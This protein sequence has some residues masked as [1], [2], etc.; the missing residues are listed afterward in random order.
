MYEVLICHQTPEKVTL[1]LDTT[2][3][4]QGVAVR[5][6]GHF[7]GGRYIGTVGC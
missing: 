2:G 6:P 1:T 3:V 4:V 5:P 7:E